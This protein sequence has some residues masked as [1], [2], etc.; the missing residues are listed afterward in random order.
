M[1]SILLS[2]LKQEILRELKTFLNVSSFEAVT[3]EKIRA[4]MKKRYTIRRNPWLETLKFKQ[5]QMDPTESVEMFYQRVMKA[6]EFCKFDHREIEVRDHLM[7][8]VSP[9]I[10]THAVTL[11]R[12]IDLL[13]ALEELKKIE[14]RLTTSAAAISVLDVNRI[15]SA[16]GNN[17][18]TGGKNRNAGG[19][20]ENRGGVFDRLG[21]PPSKMRRC[22]RCKY[23]GHDPKDCNFKD[24]K[25]RICGV[26]GH[27]SRA[28]NT[29]QAIKRETQTSS[30]SAPAT[31]ATQ[32]AGASQQTEQ[33][34]KVDI[35][36]IHPSTSDEDI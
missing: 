13:E 11:P 26:V 12:N 23:Q 27:I 30:N 17:R 20:N 8:G 2:T 31:V 5:L 15:E 10:R 18:N 35:L 4:E 29:L 25:C 34:R 6:A 1:K 3:M 36:E 7:V 22:W 21:V 24:K 32:Q 33:I 14:D 16:G 28:C 19:N 9:S